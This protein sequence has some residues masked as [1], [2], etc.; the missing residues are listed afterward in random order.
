MVTVPSRA[1]VS[2]RMQSAHQPPRHVLHASDAHPR[3]VAACR[4]VGGGWT[5][6]GAAAIGGRSASTAIGTSRA[7]SPPAAAATARLRRPRA[8]ARDMTRCLPRA[9]DGGEP[10]L[11][12]V[13]ARVC[14]AIEL[15]RLFLEVDLE[16]LLG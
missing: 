4:K 7:A 1:L 13:A 3:A 10:S 8:L 16:L 11:A 15:E 6:G 2:L 12:V 9:I 5:P 14:G